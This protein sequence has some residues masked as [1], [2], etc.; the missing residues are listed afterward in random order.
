M[1]SPVLGE[2]VA[3][4]VQYAGRK[5]LRDQGRRVRR[6]FHLDAQRILFELLE[7]RPGL[8]WP[9]DFQVD[10][11]HVPGMLRSVGSVFS[12]EE[13]GASVHLLCDLVA[14]GLGAGFVVDFGYLVDQ[15]DVLE[16]GW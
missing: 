4:F 3:Q 8:G 12:F 2:L 9:R 13:R 11:A 14:F 5:R 15:S 10:A 16:G 7:G 1:P 6:R